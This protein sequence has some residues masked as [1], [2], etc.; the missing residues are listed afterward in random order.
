MR[1]RLMPDMVTLAVD[2]HAKTQAL[3]ANAMPHWREQADRVKTLRALA[4]FKFKGPQPLLT[5]R[6]RCIATVTF[7]DA[8][9]RDPG[10]W[11]PTFKPLIDGLVDRG[12][13]PDDSWQYMD[14]PDPRH[15]IDR[16]L[17]KGW[18]RITLT[19]TPTETP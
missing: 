3:N 5:G 16:T 6:V 19:F 13:L 17:R 18:I 2:L 15:L 11:A 8:R 10:N 4:Y 12:V 9:V 7:P 1:R 14:G